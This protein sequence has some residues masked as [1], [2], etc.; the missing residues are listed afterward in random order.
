[1]TSGKG[2]ENLK[3]YNGVVADGQGIMKDA[4]YASKISH[5]PMSLHLTPPGKICKQ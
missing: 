4:A 3:R 2:A 1:V 5:Q